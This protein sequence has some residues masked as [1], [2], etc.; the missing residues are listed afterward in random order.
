MILVP[1][2]EGFVLELH[3]LCYSFR[4]TL[5]NT[6]RSGRLC[7]THIRLL[8]PGRREPVHSRL[9]SGKRWVQAIYSFE[10][11]SAMAQSAMLILL[12]FTSA[13]FAQTFQRLGACP[14]FGCVLPPDLAEFLPGQYL[15]IRLEVHAPVNGSQ[16]TGNQQPDPTLLSL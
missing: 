4:F 7:Q 15:D 8:A 9:L 12:A 13:V 5:T 14:T 6:V 2:W 3:V 11:A 16:A 10:V 1:T